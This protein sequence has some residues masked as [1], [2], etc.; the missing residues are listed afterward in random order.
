MLLVATCFGTDTL[1][2]LPI[3]GAH[4][5]CVLPPVSEQIPTSICRSGCSLLLLFA[6]CFGADP[7][8]S[9]D[10][11][12]EKFDDSPVSLAPWP[13]ASWPPGPHAQRQH[14]HMH[15]HVRMCMCMLSAQPLRYHLRHRVLKGS[16]AKASAYKYIN[17]KISRICRKQK[18]RISMG[19]SY[20]RA[21]WTSP[22][23]KN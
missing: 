6:T 10:L 20:E 23:T 2:Y 4:R 21:R 19:P 15:M 1:W 12:L 16:A 13:P 18:I 5:C 11:G 3:L 7:V 9:A 14:A 17:R 22:E 8:L